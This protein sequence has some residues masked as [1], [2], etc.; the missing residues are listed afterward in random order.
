M[1]KYGL[2]DRQ[3]RLTAVLKLQQLQREAI[4]NLSI[5]NIEDTLKYW[6]WRKTC[7][8]TLHEAVNDIL[9]LTADDIVRCLSQRAIVDGYR[10][11]IS[12]FQDLI[13]GVEHE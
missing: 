9:S 2:D 7:P 11:R 10:Q 1:E 4:P 3:L 5:Q 13:G 6:K 12:D 8:R